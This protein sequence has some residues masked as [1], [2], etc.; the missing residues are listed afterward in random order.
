MST[1]SLLGREQA[2]DEV[3]ELIERLG[4][5][6]VTLT[7]PGGVGKIRLSSEIYGEQLD[8]FGEPRA[9]RSA[10]AATGH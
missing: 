9:A 3:A 4:V 8:R 5:W 1:T 2:V 10:A 7:G 6:L